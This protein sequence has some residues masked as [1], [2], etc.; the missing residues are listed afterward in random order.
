M[1]QYSL[2]ERSSSSRRTWIEIGFCTFEPEELHVV[3]LTEDVD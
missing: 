3:L 2:M 1:E